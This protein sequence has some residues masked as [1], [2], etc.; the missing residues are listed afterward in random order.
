MRDSSVL[1]LASPGTGKEVVARAV[2]SASPRHATGR[3]LQVNC[4]AIPADLLGCGCSATRRA[5]SL[6]PWP[7]ARVVSN[8]PMAARLFL[9]EI[10]DMSLSDAG[11]AA[12]GAAGARVRARGRRAAGAAARCAARGRATQ[13]EKKRSRAFLCI[14]RRDARCARAPDRPRSVLAWRPPPCGC[15]WARRNADAMCAALGGL[16]LDPQQWPHGGLR[17]PRR[18]RDWRRPRSTA[19]H[20]HACSSKRAGT[21]PGTGRRSPGLAL[22]SCGRAAAPPGIDLRTWASKSADPRARTP[23][24][25]RGQR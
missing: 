20:G 23:T 16:D 15:R 6:V 7:R 14:P 5:P 12:A 22:L 2:R 25:W 18:P 3:S 24:A 1:I 4:G 13:H 21:P 19:L 10:G 17:M 11:Q 8:W 9:D